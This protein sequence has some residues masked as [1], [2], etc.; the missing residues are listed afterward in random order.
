MYKSSLITF[1]LFEGLSIVQVSVEEL[2]SA[3]FPIDMYTKEYA[4]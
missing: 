3:T 1:P 4:E 2:D